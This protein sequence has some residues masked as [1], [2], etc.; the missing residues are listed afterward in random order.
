MDCGRFCLGTLGRKH[1][2]TDFSMK[3]EFLLAIAVLGMIAASS[4]IP[5]LIVGT[6]YG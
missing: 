1:G 4:N 5:D 3:D 6:F 2:A